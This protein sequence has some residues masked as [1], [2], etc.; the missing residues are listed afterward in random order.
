MLELW[1]SPFFA[2]FLVF[3]LSYDRCSF[4]VFFEF[5]LHIH[6]PPFGPS[7]TMN[8]AKWL[9]PPTSTTKL[10][11]SIRFRIFFARRSSSA[12]RLQFSPPNPIPIP[13]PIPVPPPH[14]R[15][16]AAPVN[17]QLN[18]AVQQPLQALGANKVLR[19]GSLAL[20]K[21]AEL[22]ARGQHQQQQQQQQ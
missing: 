2:F 18:K 4:G 6:M 19:R 16:H 1:D 8:C 21:F 20:D 17:V 3:T 15:F 12:Q 9:Q 22:Q 11:Q 10:T 7:R 13:I 5:S 14:D